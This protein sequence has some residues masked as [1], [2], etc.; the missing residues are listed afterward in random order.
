VDCEVLKPLLRA[1]YGHLEILE[2]EF[3]DQDDEYDPFDT[4]R[5]N[6]FTRDVLNEILNPSVIQFSSL[7]ALSLSH[8]S[9]QSA[10][11]EM[12]SAFCL[13]ELRSLKLRRCPSA[14]SFLEAVVNSNEV[15]RLHSFEIIFNELP[16]PD[17][18]DQEHPVQRFWKHLKV[19][20]NSFYMQRNR[21]KT[22]CL[23]RRVYPLWPRLS[24]FSSNHSNMGVRRM[25]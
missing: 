6:A 4:D 16:E 18:F 24:D 14:L 23:L 12:A 21:E 1:N 5:I 10:F 13:S 3:M 2:L 22:S 20:R 11:E 19:L 9:F 7:R 8:V 17:V 25:S 15:I